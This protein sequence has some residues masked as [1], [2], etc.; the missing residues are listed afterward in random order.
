MNMRNAFSVL[1]LICCGLGSAS[2]AVAGS[3]QAV[4]GPSLCDAMTGNLVANCGF[5]TGDFTDW[6]LSGNTLNPAMTYYGVDGPDANS[7]NYGAYMSQDFLDGGTAPV[8]LSQTLTT[9][10]GTMYSVS[11][12]LE[13][14]STPTTG[15]T[16]MF[17]AS[18]GGTSILSLTPTVAV[19]GTVGSFTEYSF[20]ETA[21]A[22][23]TALA[24]AFEND[25][26]YWSFDDVSVTAVAPTP[27][28][29]TALLAGMAALGIL[30]LRRRL[31]LVTK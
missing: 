16:H 8:D 15:Y 7:G 14:D 12:W 1:A 30:S 2:F 23:S 20:T 29:S 10:V 9:S 13:Q 18:W 3:T 5:E 19:P 21:T 24:F 11:F 26:F 25:D 28:P 31:G 6:A 22:A 4:A 17:S 27:E